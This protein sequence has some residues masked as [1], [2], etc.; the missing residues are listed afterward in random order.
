VANR[1][2]LDAIIDEVFGA[3]DREDLTQRL[4]DAAIAYGAVNTP[5]DLSA[6]PQLRR[7][8]VATPTGPVELVAPPVEVRGSGLDLGAVPGI[9]QHSDALRKEFAA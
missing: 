5:A 7:V 8:T 6:H 1:P 2:A 9:G 3:L 4:F